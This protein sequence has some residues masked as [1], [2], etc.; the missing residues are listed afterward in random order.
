MPNFDVDD[1]IAAIAT[2][3]GHGLRSTIRISGLE[4]LK[5]LVRSFCFL[6]TKPLAELRSPSMLGVEMVL[7]DNLKLPGSLIY[8]PNHRSYTRQPSAEFHTFGSGPII[9][10]ALAKICQSGARLANPGEFTLRAFLSGRLDLTQAEA[11]LGI[12][13]AQAPTEL[14]GALKQLAG[15]LSGPLIAARDQLTYVLAELEAGL[16]FAEEDIEFI[17]REVLLARL[18]EVQTTL[19]RILNQ[20]DSRALA[21]ERIRVALIGLPNAGK[22]CLFNGLLG[23]N[24]AIVSNV[25][26]TTTDFLIGQLEIEG[27]IVELADTAGFESAADST[28]ISALAQQQREFAESNS[29][30]QLLCLDGSVVRTSWERERLATAPATTFIV[31]TKSDLPPAEMTA[32]DLRLMQQWKSEQRWLSTSFADPS[33]LKQLQQTILKHALAFSE[34]SSEIVGS[35]IARTA[36]NLRSAANYVKSAQLAASEQAGEEIIAAEIR[37]ALDDMGL[38]VGTI[39]TDDI[40]DVVFSRFCIGK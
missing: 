1:T 16:D 21:T 20:I 23:S 27:L 28:S 40:L 30:L 29:Q 36:Q 14:D 35:T 19:D 33:S 31:Q 5:C 2:A 8:W 10:L 13:D 15:G 12:I 34:T 6:S 22:S 37:A 38:V 4:C 3:A 24:R 7:D 17:S 11:V 32:V 25:P 26:G 18:V 9:Q 39:Y